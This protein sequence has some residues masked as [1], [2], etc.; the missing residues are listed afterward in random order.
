MNKEMSAEK[1]RRLTRKLD[2]TPDERQGE[3]ETNKH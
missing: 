3:R 1:N 2:K